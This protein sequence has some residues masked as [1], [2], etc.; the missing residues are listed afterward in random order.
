MQIQSA[1][2]RSKAQYDA[3]MKAVAAAIREI[4]LCQI[5]AHS[6]GA[7]ITCGALKR[8]AELHGLVKALVLVEPGPP[9]DDM[10]HLG[11]I[12]TRMISADYLDDRF[13]RFR[14][15]IQT[16]KDQIQHLEVMDLPAH[17]I[18]GNTHF[19]MA[20]RNSDEIGEELFRWLEDAC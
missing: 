20:D 16:Y 14:G 4:G 8:D 12:R 3:E 6:N 5:V 7:A 19:P 10:L 17:G 18:T 9:V 1:R 11:T 15:V 2:R 13:P